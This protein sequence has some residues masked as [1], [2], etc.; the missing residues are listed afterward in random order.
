MGD[1]MGREWE[2]GWKGSWKGRWKGRGDRSVTG[3][4]HKERGVTR[5]SLASRRGGDTRQGTCTDRWRV[6]W[7]TR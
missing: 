6:R 4:V 7:M 3:A 2:R 5:G 1:E